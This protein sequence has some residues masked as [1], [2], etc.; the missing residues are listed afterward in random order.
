M[1]YLYLVWSNLKRKKVRS[2]LTLASILVAFLLFGYLSAIRMALSQGVEVAGADRLVTRHKVSIIQLLPENYER[3]IEQ[4]EGVADAVHA[5]WFGGIYQRPSNFFPSFPVKPE[6]YLA[7]FPEFLLS[8]EARAR[9]LRTRTGAVVGRATAE[10]FDWKVGDVIPIQS[11]IWR[12]EDGRDTWEFEIVGIYQGAEKATDTTQFLFRHDYFDE[13]RAQGR[14]QIGWYTV[15]VEDPQRAEQVAL[16]I[17]ALFENSP[18]ETKTE[19]EGAFVGA[20]AKQVGNIAAIMIAILGAVFFTILLVSGNTMAQSVRERV[21]E[22]ALLKAL[23][24][25]G[26]QVMGMVLAESISLVGLGGGIGLGLAWILISLGD[27]T[28]GALPF[29]FIPTRDLVTGTVLVVT[30]GL[31]AGFFPAMQALRLRVAD[32]LRRL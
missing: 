18:A 11:P 4:I 19:T 30:L 2:I 15:R 25:T 17:D 26:R 3:Q 21:G 5:T 16:A 29:F 23:G 31:V 20:F 14:G 24:F 9:W 12:R 32:A 8:D 10:R 22:L 7:M 13:A 6:E 28:G 1:K 27:P